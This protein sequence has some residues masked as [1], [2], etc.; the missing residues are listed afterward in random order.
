MLALI[1][2]LSWNCYVAY[3]LEQKKIAEEI[4]LQ[5]KQTAQQIQADNITTLSNAARMMTDKELDEKLA[6][7]AGVTGNEGKMSITFDDEAQS[8]E[9]YSDTVKKAPLLLHI[10]K[11][12]LQQHQLQFNPAFV[13]DS[14]SFDSL[15]QRALQK[16]G[17]DIPHAIYGVK[18][19]RQLS[20]H[21]FFSSRFILDFFDPEMYKVGF[22][23][24]SGIILIRILPNIITSLLICILLVLAFIFFNKSYAMQLQM[25]TFRESLFSNITHELKSPLTSLK[26]IVN[27]AEN[28]RQISAQHIAFARKEISRMHLLVEKILSFGRLSPEQIAL[29]KTQVN[30][31]ACIEEAIEATSLTIKENAAEIVVH[32]T[33][34]LNIYADKALLTNVIITILD[35]AIK[36]SAPLP[37]IS[38]VYALEKD[39]AQIRISD[40]GCGIPPEFQKKV[41][42]PF[43]RIPDNDRH[44]VKGHGLGLSFVQQVVQ[45]HN[46]KVYMESKTG[47]GTAVII[48]LPKT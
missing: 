7:A 8:D 11:T 28:E 16:K 33:G 23:I 36:Y 41:F 30:I 19:Y 29:N 6:F 25:A 46:G 35:N 22:D 48:E 17:W 2:A 40:N 44:N 26:L 27:E 15:L 14:S 45:M 24:P 21:G 42:E 4:D 34:A 32:S 12:F 1:V 18:K 10:N 37:Q 20:G 31:A 43:F 9:P 39:K 13:K 38:I 5:V 3:M 47:T